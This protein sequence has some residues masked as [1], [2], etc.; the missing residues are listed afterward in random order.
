MGNNN[1]SGVGVLG[2]P[3]Q[4][5]INYNVEMF[6]DSTTTGAPID[7]TMMP[8]MMPTMAPFID[9][10][11]PRINDA[12]EAPTTTQLTT[13]KTGF[14]CTSNEDCMNMD[15]Y[16]STPGKPPVYSCPTATCSAGVCSCEPSCKLDPY[17]GVC[18]QALEKI[19]GE[20]Y[21]VESTGQPVA[22]T[23]KGITDVSWW[24]VEDY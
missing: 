8:T 16:R 15:S 20:S 12:S 4:Q 14:Q 13:N 11:A 21:C 7:E 3:V 9:P 5:Q 6:D 22:I 24:F 23:S 1:S 2:L 19:G 10:N 18:C 17:S